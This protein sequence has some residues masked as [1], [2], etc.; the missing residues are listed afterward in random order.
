MHSAPHVIVCGA[1]L[2][3]LTTAWQLK[4]SGA[5]VTVLEASDVVGG[6]IGSTKLDGYL[7]EHGPNSCMLTPELAQ[8]VDALGVTPMLRDAAP[9]AQRRY[10]V[11]DGRALAVPMSPGA[12]LRSPLFSAAAKLRLL[13]E[14]FIGR[15]DA[16]TDES[17]ADFVTRRLGKEVLT[18]AVDPF[19]SGVYAGDP[20][21][22]SI[23]HA[24]PRLAALEREHGSLIHGAIAAG[25]RSRAERAQTGLPAPRPR[26]VSFVDGMGTLPLAIANDIGA[27][28]IQCGAVVT[29]VETDADGV[30]VTVRRDGTLSTLHADA[31]VCT[32]PLHALTA[33]QLPNATH[34]AV[35]H[36]R[37][38]PYPAVASLAL[39]FRRADVA[40]AL[41]GFGCLIPS[42]EQRKTLGVL[43]SSTLF[44]GRAPDG[45]VLLTCF[46]GGVRHPALGTASVQTLVEL[47]TSDLRALLGVT[48]APTFVHR[49]SWPAAIPQYNLGHA[50][51]GRAADAIEALVPGLLVDGQFRR[52]VSVGD[53][54][55][56]G[57]TIA[58]RA[59]R[60]DWADDRPSRRSRHHGAP[61]RC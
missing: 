38:L 9:S 4:R 22:L 56:A 51:H 31:V 29:S 20:E 37:T 24:F 18:W 60:L 15:R 49:T 23:A 21:Q 54:V 8:L 52:G 53:C 39:G 11:R 2:T 3:G 28:S 1:G 19:V 45:H 47:V 13:A 25:K 14:P 26:M 7:I 50:A 57:E 10:I 42:V 58:Q 48:A 40:H 17:V 46:I 6:V 32:L 27:D 55:A 33:L 43:F 41:D 35:A 59:L 36:L 12:M 44:D 16:D 30:S 34:D 61:G 5:R